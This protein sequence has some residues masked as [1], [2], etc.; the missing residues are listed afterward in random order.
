MIVRNAKFNECK[1]ISDIGS[2][3]YTKTFGEMNY[4]EKL[5][6]DSDEEEVIKKKNVMKKKSKSDKLD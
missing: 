2:K 1:I 3:T 4:K 6:I 5:L